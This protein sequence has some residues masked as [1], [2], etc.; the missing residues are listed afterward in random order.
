MPRQPLEVAARTSDAPLGAWCGVCGRR[1]HSH[2]LSLTEADVLA[3]L[4]RE[5]PAT[6]ADLARGEGVEAAVDGRHD[7]GARG[8]GGWSR[9]ARTRPMAARS[10]SADARRVRRAEGGRGCEADVAH[11]GRWAAA[12]S[13]TETTLFAAGRSSRDCLTRDGHSGQ[14]ASGLV[15]GSAHHETFTRSAA[16]RSVVARVARVAAPQ[17]QAVLRRPEHFA[18]RHLDDTAR[19]DLAGLSADPFRA[20][21]G[22]VTFA[23]QIAPSCWVRFAGAWVER[24]DRRGSWC[25]PR[26]RPPCSRWPLPSSH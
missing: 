12:D 24:L 11:P 14:R 26:P 23:G 4:G 3:R 22:I 16:E 2:G 10:T 18:D 25:G 17:F 7:R 8:D 20:P 19:D 1:P 21:A 5:G 15:N 13:T 9:A 6:T